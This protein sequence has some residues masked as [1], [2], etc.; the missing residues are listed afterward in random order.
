MYLT[1]GDGIFDLRSLGL[2]KK[3]NWFILL[4]SLV[5][6]IFLLN[7]CNQMTKHLD[8]CYI[9]KNYWN[10]RLESTLKAK[11]TRSAKVPW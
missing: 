5:A 1:S 2:L 11:H 4:Q 8:P 9:A 7:K 6:M 10:L 3:Q